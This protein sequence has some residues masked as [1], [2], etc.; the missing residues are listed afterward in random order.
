MLLIVEKRSQYDELNWKVQKLKEQVSKQVNDRRDSMNKYKEA[1]SKIKIQSDEI[2]KLKQI[3]S[4][5]ESA[6]S[7]YGTPQT[8]V[9]HSFQ[10]TV[11]KFNCYSYS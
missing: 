11:E 4:R 5:L 1:V 10:L 3:V 9:L 7:S 8:K 2:D 6:K